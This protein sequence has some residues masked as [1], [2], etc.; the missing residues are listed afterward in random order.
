LTSYLGFGIE[1]LTE[2]PEKRGG[3]EKRA[4]KPQLPIFGGWGF[5]FLPVKFFTSLKI[6][7]GKL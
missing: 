4:L 5:V 2:Q 1:Y 7:A 3:H 6:I